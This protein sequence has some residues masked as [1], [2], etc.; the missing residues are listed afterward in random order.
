[1]A[2][3]VS[4]S[5]RD[6]KGEPDGRA[7]NNSSYFNPGSP[8][9]FETYGTT[10]GALRQG[11]QHT[12]H[13]F[14]GG[15]WWN[16]I[17][18]YK[19]ADYWTHFATWNVCQEE[20]DRNTF[21]RLHTN[22]NTAIEYRRVVTYVQL[23]SDLKWYRVY[24]G[25][26][27]AH[28]FFLANEVNQQYV[29]GG[30]ISRTGA[31][32]GPV[33]KWVNNP[34]DS[35]TKFCLHQVGNTP[36]GMVNSEYGTLEVGSAGNRIR[37]YYS[38]NSG[39]I[40][41][42]IFTGTE[43]RLVK[44]DTGGAEIDSNARILSYQGGDWFPN[45][46]SRVEDDLRPAFAYSRYKRLT[47]EFQWFTAWCANE[48]FSDNKDTAN[49][50][51]SEAYYRANLPPVFFE[52]PTIPDTP[53]PDSGTSEIT[54]GKWYSVSDTEGNPYFSKTS[55]PVVSQISISPA[56]TITLSPS[57]TQQFNYVISGSNLSASPSGLWSLS[58]TTNATID[59]V[60]GQLITKPTFSGDLNQ[61]S[62]Y[63]TDV[64]ITSQDIPSVSARKTIRLQPPAVGTKKV[65]ITEL[66]PDA[67]GESGIRV[68]IFYAHSTNLTGNKIAD[69]SSVSISSTLENGH[70]VMYIS[71][72]ELENIAVGTSVVVVAENQTKTKGI[73]G[74]ASG[75]VILE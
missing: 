50:G 6:M 17:P 23:L 3:S 25:I 1:M 36:A 73:R 52:E 35:N 48:I 20:Q 49:A 14:N 40:F 26:A 58:D 32:G 30:I 38:Y 8:N 15:T 18:E 67:A 66:E 13:L 61:T 51:V 16:P 34:S 75:T 39:Q 42:N 33:I 69:V 72:P 22:T 64:I 65:K 74:V 10:A 27:N 11:T 47:T 57:Q 31:G 71:A 46:S 5:V 70:A 59:S 53:D 19:D 28:V 2:I 54:I 37:L 56:E 12:G 45:V 68:S 24:D 55:D 4:E 43:M 21:A 41:K 7:A 29:A 60:S 63:I 44:W 9:N 62:Y